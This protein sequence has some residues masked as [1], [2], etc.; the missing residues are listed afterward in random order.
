M[1]RCF[2]F[3]GEVCK[4]HGAQHG[5]TT[6]TYLDVNRIDTSATICSVAARVE[7]FLDSFSHAELH[8][9]S[10]QN[11]VNCPHSLIGARCWRVITIRYHEKL[12][13]VMLSLDTL[14]TN[15]RE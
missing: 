2:C 13:T 5:Q 1:S 12:S 4:G 3:R 15:S 11:N 6:Q 9:G 14:P 8:L 10:R 7:G